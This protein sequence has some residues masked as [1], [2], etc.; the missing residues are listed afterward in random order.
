[1][2]RRR[3]RV[4]AVVDTNVIAYFLLGTEE[5]VEESRAFLESALT[6]EAP[7]VW[8]AGLANVLWMGVRKKILTMEDAIARLV[9]AGS[10]GIRST[11]SRDLW[12]GALIRAGEVGIAVYDT[13]FVELAVRRKLPLATFDKAVLTAFPEVAVRPSA[14]V[15]GAR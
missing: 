2:D 6:L 8:E 14:L 3:P 15:P 10:L 11:P 13:L 7:G 12:Q 1:M 4:S 5:Y 9:C